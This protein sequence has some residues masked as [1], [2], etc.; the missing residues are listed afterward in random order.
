MKTSLILFITLLLTLPL[1]SINQNVNDSIRA[2]ETYSKALDLAR[3]GEFSQAIDT[4]KISLF[5]RE[6][7]FTKESREYGIVQNALGISYR[8]VGNLEKAIEHFLLAEKAYNSNKAENKL[9]IAGL[10]NNIGILYKNKLNYTTSLDYLFKSLEIYSNNEEIT[11]ADIADVYYNIADNY[12]NQNNYNK[13]IEI[14]DKYFPDAYD[15]TKMYFLSLKAASLKEL[16]KNKDAYIAY[17]SL[18]DYTI[19]YFSEDDINV[20]FEYLNIASFLVS[21]SEFEEARKILLKAEEILA[22]NEIDKGRISF[23]YNKAVGSYYKALK[24]E[25]TDIEQFRIQ[26]KINLEKAIQYYQL[27]L[28][29][30]EL[31]ESKTSDIIVENTQSLTY[32]LDALKLIADTYAEIADLYFTSELSEKLSAIKEAL[33]Y[34]DI[35]SKMIQQARRSMYS[36]EDKILLAELEE[37]T[38]FKM[39]EAAYKAYNLDSNPEVLDF[40]FTSAE[41]MKASAVFDRLSDQFAKENSLVPDSL[42]DLERAL[43]Y[44]ITTQNEALFNLQNEANGNADEIARTDSLLFQLKKQRDELNQYLE[45][46]F[47]QYYEMKYADAMLGTEEVRRNL[48]SNEVL[49]EYVL[50]ET[51]S[52]PDVFAFLISAEKSGLYKLNADSTFIPALEETFRFLSNPAYL[53]TRNENSINYCVSAHYLYQTL[54]QPFERHIEGK[55]TIVIPDGKLSYLPFDALLTALPDTSGL[56]SFN[57]LPY[58]IRDYTINY[59]YSANLLFKFK[60]QKRQAS[61]RLL[62]FAPEYN[63]D[64]VRF[65]NESLV[66][67]PLPGIQREVALIADAVKAYIYQGSEATEKNFREQSREH[68]I[69][70]LAMHA[71]INDSLPAFSRFAFA[72]NQDTSPNN[73]GWLNTADIYNLDLK[74]RLTV[75]SACNTGRGNLRKGEGV[76]SLARGFLYAG[77]PSIVMSMWEVEDNAGTE[78]MHTFYRVLKKGRSTDY[79]L[80]QAK[81]KYLENANPRLAHPHYWLGYVSIGSTYPLFRSYDFYFFGLL[82]LALAGITADQI[83]RFRRSGKRRYKK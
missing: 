26:K 72:Q 20:V 5:F 83:I 76:M 77:C 38:F 14:A 62:A 58:V 53:F 39:I 28:K 48:K 16:N 31:Y 50:N 29:A 22:R 45:V 56:I 44:K 34:Y 78:I 71:F 46:N 67:I 25:S 74:A 6:K 68:D 43:N 27:A 47:P 35:T 36:D 54:L 7:Y 10:Y 66:L 42:T 33:K 32:S 8:N 4:F 30:L 37:A 2:R 75:L 55:K 19:N 41:R 24:V 9:A 80:R 64:T 3:S 81:L 13:V 11:D 18:F 23:L 63:T 1:Y 12:Y 70:H 73:D 69:L 51:D 57:N 17:Q 61:K 82:I 59:S 65:D 60:K 21:I 49:L 79:A 15:D 52:I 40:A